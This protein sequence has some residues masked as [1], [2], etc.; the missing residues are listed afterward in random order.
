MGTKQGPYYDP[1]ANL[2][3]AIIARGVEAH[4][5]SFLQSDWC[6]TL[7]A[8]CRM[9]D[10]LHGN[11]NMSGRGKVRVSTAHMEVEGG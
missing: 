8:I 4:D 2:A 5:V 1:W 10:E 6:D 7:R 11:R 9:D 3:A